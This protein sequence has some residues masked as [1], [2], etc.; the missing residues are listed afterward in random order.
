[1]NNNKIYLLLILTSILLVNFASAET[2]FVKTNEI[3]PL[4][5]PCTLDGFPCSASAECNATVKFANQSYVINNQEMVNLNNGDFEINISLNET[6]TYP[7]KFFCQEAGQNNTITPNIQANP[8]GRG[9]DEG[10]GIVSFGILS[11][12]LVLV[13]VFLKIG[14][15]LGESDKMIPIAFFFVI[16][17]IIMAIYSLHLSYVFTADILQYNSLTPVTSTIYITILWSIVGLF[18]I[19]M[20]LM[21]ISFIKELSKI[22]DKHTFGDGFDPITETYQL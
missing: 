8:S 7:S 3:T 1:M 10:Q 15:K 20:I 9:F 19:S 17:A 6:G 13:F 14:F 5:I 2:I 11:G 12:S 21:L 4:K 16:F 22:N 18:L